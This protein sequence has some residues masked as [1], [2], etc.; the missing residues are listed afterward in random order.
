MTTV[1]VV[2][3]LTQEANEWTIFQNLLTEDDVVL[4]EQ[5]SFE[6]HYKMANMRSLT[7][8]KRQKTAG[9]LALLSNRL[10]EAGY[11]FISRENNMYCPYCSEFTA[12]RFRCPVG[13]RGVK[14]R[15][16]KAVY[17]P[18]GLLEG[19]KKKGRGGDVL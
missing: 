19:E 17:P 7:W 4:P 1:V 5:M 3:N 11:R 6:V 13:P 9:E 8:L 2:F 10:Y 16:A 14:A 12:V 18:L 15:A